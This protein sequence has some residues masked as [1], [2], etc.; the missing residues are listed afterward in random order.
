MSALLQGEATNYCILEIFANA[1]KGT[2]GVSMFALLI[3]LA[4][5]IKP[6][7][8]SSSDTKLER[9][10][11][12][13]PEVE[14]INYKSH[15]DVAAEALRL[16][17]GKGVDIIVNNTGPASVPS[18]FAALRKKGGTISLV[19]FLEGI[20]GEW[21]TSLFLTLLTRAAKIQ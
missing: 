14:G 4:A 18:D 2:G 1:L 7:I 9:I 15:S 17:H 16:T 13:S 19:G 20:Q 21:D 8:T 6:I 12:L 3:C 5:G 11:K 10:K